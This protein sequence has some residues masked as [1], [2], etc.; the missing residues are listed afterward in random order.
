M[1]VSVRRDRE[2]TVAVEKQLSIAQSVCVFLAFG[3]QHAMCMRH[4]VICGMSRSATFFS[5]LS[6]KRYDFRKKKKY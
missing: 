2:T 4:T 5:T 1:Y 3:I 6:H